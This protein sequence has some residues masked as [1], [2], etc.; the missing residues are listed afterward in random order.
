MFN[1]MLLFAGYFFTCTSPA[2]FN[3]M[4]SLV[5][6]INHITIHTV[7]YTFENATLTLKR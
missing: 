6:I 5:Y 3:G 4:L 7:L 2:V 1:I